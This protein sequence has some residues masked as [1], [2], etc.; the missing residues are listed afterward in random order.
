LENLVFARID[1]SANEHPQLQVD[2][3]PA[4]LF[5]REGLKSNPVKLPT[6]ANLKELAKLINK[7]IKAQQYHITRE[8]L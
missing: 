8:E 2:D 5:Y 4:L 7:N 3:Y 1:G 6:K